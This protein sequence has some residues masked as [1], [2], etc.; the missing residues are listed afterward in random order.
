MNYGRG[1]S[2]LSSLISTPFLSSWIITI[3]L[4]ALKS[5]QS[6]PFYYVLLSDG[7]E[8]R[9]LRRSPTRNGIGASIIS[10][11]AQGKIGIYT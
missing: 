2:I 1:K 7:N 8:S 11:K 10:V 3:S 5:L 4:S 9:W 6:K